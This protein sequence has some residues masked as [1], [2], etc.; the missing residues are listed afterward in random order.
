MRMPDVASGFHNGR[1]FWG[2]SAWMHCLL[3][4]HTILTWTILGFMFHVL[5]LC[6]VLIA[7]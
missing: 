7:K 4:Q 3:T 6:M 5:F 2:F 1:T